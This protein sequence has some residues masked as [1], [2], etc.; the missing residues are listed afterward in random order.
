MDLKQH[1]PFLEAHLSLHVGT[2]HDSF[3]FQQ[4]IFTNIL[5]KEEKFNGFAPFFHLFIYFFHP[6]ECDL[7][8]F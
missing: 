5:V 6:S 1:M 4:E 8:I 2:K 3:H 7:I